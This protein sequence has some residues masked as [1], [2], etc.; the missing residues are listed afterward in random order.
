MIDDGAPYQ[1]G[2]ILSL[3]VAAGGAILIWAVK[4]TT[5]GFN[6][7]T[8][9][10]ILLVVGVVGLL[11]SLAFWSRVVGASRRRSHPGNSTTLV[12]R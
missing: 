8:A 5:S 9:G 10:V 2:V 1:F 11:L 6:V 12:E 4:T 7:H 3:L